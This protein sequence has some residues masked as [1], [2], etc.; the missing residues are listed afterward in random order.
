MTTSPCF[1]G[2]TA[3]GVFNGGLFLAYVQQILAPTFATTPASAP[4]VAVGKEP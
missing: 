1:N 3:P 4:S 2:L